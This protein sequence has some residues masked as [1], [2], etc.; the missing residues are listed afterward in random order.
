MCLGATWVLIET[1]GGCGAMWFNAD[2]TLRVV[3]RSPPSPPPSPQPPP[4]LPPPAA[5]PAPPAAPP[6]D[7]LHSRLLR[8]EGRLEAL[9][10]ERNATLA[11]VEAL[12]AQNRC[13][14]AA[15]DET[16][17]ACVLSSADE[18]SRAGNGL[19][20]IHIRGGT[21]MLKVQGGVKR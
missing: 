9:E 20:A 19:D 10:S 14:R 8:L 12:E 13:L 1:N 2:K 6:L 4:A 7:A 11:R 16:S 15:H 21:A 3:V 5:P 18:Y 17:G